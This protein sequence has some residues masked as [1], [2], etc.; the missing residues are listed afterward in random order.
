MTYIVQSLVSLLL[1]CIS[2]LG[3]LLGNS[4]LQLLTIDIGT[5]GSFFDYV[6]DGILPIAEV[7][8]W[9]AYAL[10]ILL[11]VWAL[12]KVMFV[13]E[14]TGETPLQIMGSTLVAGL[15]VY[16]GPTLITFFEGLFNSF[17]NFLLT[18][19]I[20]GVPVS[21]EVTFDIMAGTATSVMA[22]GISPGTTLATQT[23]A[24]VVSGDFSLIALLAALI[25]TILIVYEF[26]MFILEC[27]ERYV[28]LGVLFYM[29]PLA[30]A[31][32]GTK[33]TRNVFGSFARMFGSQMFLLLTNVVFFRLFISAQQS[34]LGVVEGIKTMYEG[35]EGVETPSYATI[36][37]LYFF[38]L[39]AILHV[40][41]RLDAYLG[42]L[43]LSA[44]QTGRGLGQSIVMAAVGIQ[45]S[46]GAMAGVGRWVGGTKAGQAAKAAVRDRTTDF[47]RR[48]DKD[49]GE[50]AH[51]RAG[52]GGK[53]AT[54]RRVTLSERKAETSPTVWHH[55]V[56][57]W[58]Y[59]FT[60]LT[61]RI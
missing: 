7:L 55:Y 39:Y 37:I 46:I 48:V 43:G 15:T 41:T 21:G 20:E 58:G 61:C 19:T 13:P 28:V 59:F 31:M 42:T 49:Y 18:M 40:G 30:F 22:A 52:S 16:M 51:F 5:S 45:R 1:T 25:L 24:D 4:M 34:Y 33:S 2:A 47:V 57:R 17:Y 9:L 6:F 12:L 23:A 27:I 10:L 54:F 29:S 35:M 11:A 50:A 8:R 36:T 56:G 38:M 26:V 53:V 32:A 14:G 3:D 44:A 60:F